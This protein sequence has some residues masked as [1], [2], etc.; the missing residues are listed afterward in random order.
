MLFAFDMQAQSIKG[1]I[2]D[3]AS[4]DSIPL[5]VAVYRSHRIASTADSKGRFSIERHNGWQLSFT[6]VG[7]K[8]K[9]I[10]VNEKT[11]DSLVIKLSPEV[12]RLKEVFVDAKQGKYSRKNNPAVELMKRV[13][14]A[15]KRT[16]LTKNDFYEYYKYQKITLAYNKVS[17]EDLLKQKEKGNRNW[18][19]KQVEY[20]PMNGQLICPVQTSETVTRQIYRKEP[21]MKRSFVLGEKS[22]GIG[23]LVETAGNILDAMVKDAFTDV[24]IYDDQI[25]L[26]KYPFTSPIGKDAISFY[27]FYITDTLMVGKDKC[28]ELSFVPNNQQDF[29]FR[30]D[31]WVLADSTLHVRKVSLTIPQSSSVNFVDKMIIDQEFIQLPDGQWVLDYDNMLIEMRVNKYLKN[32]VVIRNT[33]CSEYSF[34]KLPKTDFAGKA[35]LTTDYDARNRGNEFW[36]RFRT[37]ELSQSEKSVNSF[38][39]NLAGIPGMKPLLF[40][41]KAL[42]NNYIGLTGHDSI[43]SKVDFGP[44]TTLVNKNIVDGWR[45]RLSARTTAALCPHFFW[46]GYIARGIDSKKWYYGTTFTYSFNA[47]RNE[48]WEFPIRQLS[49]T[50]EKDI[51][52]PSDKYLLTNKDN[53]FMAFKVRSIDKMYFYNRQQ[54]EFKYET[55]A[56]LAYTLGIKTEGINSA[57]KMLF[58]KQDGSFLDKEIRTTE[59]HAGLRYAPGETFFYTKQKRYPI[60]RNVPIFTLDHSFSPVNFLGSGYSSN[61]TEASMFKRVWLNSWGKLELY[62]SGG[63]QWNQ[64]PFPLLIMPRVNLGWLTPHGSYTFQLMNNMEFLNDRYA[65][66]HISWDMHG[67]LFNRIP[68]VKRLKW[69]EYISVRGMWGHLTDKNNPTLSHNDILLQ[70]PEGCNVMTDTPYI[71]GA[72]GIHNIFKFLEIDYLHRFTYRDLDTAIRNGVRFTINF[73]F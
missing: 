71:E 17:P 52:S 64:V 11:K 24:D 61:Y 51:M 28:I 66:W 4:G 15:N 30:G 56:G 35:E 6:A 70:F 72:I 3:A 62:F 68:L 63:I 38:A 22:D 25:R 40:V 73:S 14:A 2:I 53:F 20:C 47:K 5:A 26:L 59:L 34:N 57:A 23:N 12:Q 46:D 16:D 54:L 32:A 8:K 21:K 1:I 67:K 41:A 7:Y 10:T 36:K 49:F 60:N 44:V 50:S 45:F 69:R 29:G 42:M 43:P 33:K 58:I 37:V 39:D 19:I 13:I 31:I 9:V 48:K 55:L 65:M 27:R 18:L